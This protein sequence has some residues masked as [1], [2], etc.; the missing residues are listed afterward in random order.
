MMST[1]PSEAGHVRPARTLLV[2]DDDEATRDSY[3]SV[4]LICPEDEYRAI[5]EAGSFTDLQFVDITPQVRASLR[6]SGVREGIGVGEDV[7]LLRVHR[8][9]QDDATDLAGVAAGVVQREGSA[10]RVPGE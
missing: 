4:N 9:Q 8:V 5:A 6:Q 3:G 10:E 2:V 1:S 7:G